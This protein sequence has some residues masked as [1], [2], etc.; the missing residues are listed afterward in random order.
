M[1]RHV[2]EA[3]WVG[4]EGGCMGVVVNVSCLHVNIE[5]AGAGAGGSQRHVCGC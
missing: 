3:S 2:H 5:G 4:V 1:H